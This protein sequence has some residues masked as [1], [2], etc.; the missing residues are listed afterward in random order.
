MWGVDEGTWV[1]VTALAAA[2]TALIYIALGIFAWR[3][4][5]EA[6][7]L[8]EEQTRE[9]RQLQ[10]EQTRPFV[11]VDLEPVR[12][13]FFLVIENIGRTM[14]QNVVIKFDKPLT[15]SFRE[16]GKLDEA[17][18]FSEPIPFLAPGKRIRVAFDTLPARR[19][20][21]L[22]LVYEVMLRYEGPTGREYGERYVLDMGMYAAA[23]I[24]EKGLPE[25]VGEVE[26]VRKELGKWTSGIRG[27]LVHT[28]DKRR[29]DRRELRWYKAQ[30]PREKGAKALAR[31]LWNRA[32]QRIGDR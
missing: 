15:S 4:V 2:A 28:V 9:A 31:S 19:E 30:M 1:G 16:T 13:L 8:R 11:V 6:R 25:L 10:E 5:T 29:E 17:A 32:L 14:A 3:Q 20:T 23:A 21:G 22:P 27:L 26:K 18:L 24:S 7:R 12:I